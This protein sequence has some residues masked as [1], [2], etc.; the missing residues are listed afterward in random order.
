VSIKAATILNCNICTL[1]FSYLELPV[2]MTSLT[3]E[4]WQPLIEKVEKKLVT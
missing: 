4:D 1:P 2:I 3:K